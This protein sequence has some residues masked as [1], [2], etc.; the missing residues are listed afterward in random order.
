MSVNR[1][2]LSKARRILRQLGILLDLINDKSVF[3]GI[4]YK[5]I[6]SLENHLVMA[7]AATANIMASL[8]DSSGFLS[9]HPP[10]RSKDNEH[11]NT[12]TPKHNDGVSK[13]EGGRG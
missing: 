4:H 12:L 1:G 9:V 3:T 10:L 8:G 5:E 13:G 7:R 2:D 11:G 6:E